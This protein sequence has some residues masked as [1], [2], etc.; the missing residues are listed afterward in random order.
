VRT[1]LILLALVGCSNEAPR[2]K[3]K[4]IDVVTFRRMLVNRDEAVNI[5]QIKIEALGHNTARYIVVLKNTQSN[6][7]VYGEFP[8]QIVEEINAAKIP[9]SVK[10]KDE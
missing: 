2:D 10:A 9:Y 4:Q 7:V 1:F 3:E 5:E 6:R 8:G